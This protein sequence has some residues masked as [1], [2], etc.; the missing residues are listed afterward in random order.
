MLMRAEAA[1]PQAGARPASET[2]ADHHR[3]I[4]DIRPGQQ[5]AER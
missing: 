5:L 2:I 4:E 3:E 1:I